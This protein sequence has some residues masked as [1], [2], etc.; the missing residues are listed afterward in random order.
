M[1]PNRGKMDLFW[2][3]ALGRVPGV[4]SMTFLKLLQRFGSPEAVFRAPLRSLL[5]V[6][7]VG[8]RVAEAILAFRDRGEVESELSRMDRLGI[9][10]I[11]YGREPYPPALAAIPDPPP[12]LFVRGKIVPE[13]RAAVAIVGSRAAS[14]YGLKTTYRIARDLAG[15]GITVVSGLAR[16]ID[17]EAHRGA[18]AGGGR[19]IAVMG[20]GLNVIYPPENRELFDR[21]AERGAVV[22]EYPLDAEPDAAHF[23]TRNRII[24]GM[25]LGT[26]IVEAAPKSGSLITA[27]L[28]LEQGREVFAVPGSVD[29]MR[30]R[31]THHLIRQGACLVETAQ[32]IL[33][34]LGPLLDP[35]V[36][37]PEQVAPP[38]APEEPLS[39]EE[40]RLLGLL[41]E[42]P[43]HIDELSR[44]CGLSPS[45]VSVALLQLE[46]KGR[47]RQLP[48]K[49]FVRVG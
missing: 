42:E 1:L 19:T 21:V 26:A 30:S 15:T 40:D 45:S 8:R 46:L 47:V 22:S 23:P 39:V 33:D 10:M 2:W 27:Q 3:L 34:E 6:E 25:C 43:M 5:E 48:G 12:Y 4:G 17:S 18:L 7:R 44:E 38:P 13:D 9:E 41:R 37:R 49:L 36:V 29:S 16:G 24:S 32:D 11:L 35:R 14:Q 20:S 31:G 28:A